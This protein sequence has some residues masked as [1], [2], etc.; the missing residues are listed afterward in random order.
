MARIRI[1]RALAAKFLFGDA[2]GEVEITNAGF[3]AVAD[4]LVL[5]IKGITVPEV[6]EVSCQIT[7]FTKWSGN[8]YYAMK[9]EPW[10]PPTELKV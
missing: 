1:A 7:Q 10:P 3:D 6:E 9:F 5:E 4:A 2:D 8:R